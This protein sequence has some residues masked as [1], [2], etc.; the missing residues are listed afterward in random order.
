MRL[1]YRMLASRPCSSICNGG[2]RQALASQMS[3]PHQSL[4]GVG[5]RH[6]VVQHA[7]RPKKEYIGESDDGDGKD[8]KRKVRARFP[9]LFPVFLFRQD[10]QHHL[11]Y[12]LTFCCII[13]QQAERLDSLIAHINS[14]HG[15][16]TLM[17]LGA[18]VEDPNL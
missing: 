4:L 18:K 11:T 7:K 8:P 17:K 6:R 2:Q 12:H 16:N 15:K 14:V 5:A 10:R 9:V 13:S 3:A 1:H